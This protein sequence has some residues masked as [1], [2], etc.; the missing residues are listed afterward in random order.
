MKVEVGKK[1]GKT[2]LL[3]SKKLGW[4]SFSFQQCTA[5]IKAG[6]YIWVKATKNIADKILHLFSQSVSTAL[7]Q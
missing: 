7:F 1:N 2:F 5:L 3:L 4:F 6:L